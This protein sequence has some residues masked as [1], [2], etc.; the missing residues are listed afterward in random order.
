M[1]N[2]VIVYLDESLSLEIYMK[3]PDG[4]RILDSKSN[5]NIYNIKLLRVLYGVKQSEQIWYNRLNKFLL[6]KGY[7]NN[8]DSPFMFIRKILVGFLCRFGLC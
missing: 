5:R 6:K 4:L 2:V 1:M 3:V 7:I 8:L